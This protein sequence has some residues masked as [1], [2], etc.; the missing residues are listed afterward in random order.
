MVGRRRAVGLAPLSATTFLKSFFQ[1]PGRVGA[2][3]PSSRYLAAAMVD[4]IDWSATGVVVEYGPGTGV[5]TEAIEAKRASETRFFAIE[6][7]AELAAVVRQRCPTVTV[8]EDS[9]ENVAAICQRE[10][11][12]RVDA[13]VCGLPWASF[14][15][16]LQD[17]CF[18]AMLRVL[19]PGGQFVSFAYW[20]GMA[21]PAAWRFRKKLQATFASVQRSPTVVRNLPPAFVYRCRAAA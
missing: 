2:I 20:Q 6:R 16:P 9:V 12:E 21:L 19:K 13:I 5:F 4:W 18:E 11:I 10:S 17:A 8:F 14:P 3:A 7:S 1:D 15:E